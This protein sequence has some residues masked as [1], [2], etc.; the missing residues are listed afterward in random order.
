MTTVAQWAANQGVGGVRKSVQVPL[1]AGR[2]TATIVAGVSP[3]GR[4]VQ[5]FTVGTIGAGSSP[6]ETMK[7]QYLVP[8]GAAIDLSAAATAIAYAAT[9]GV[10]DVPMTTAAHS[11]G[12]GMQGY[13]P[14][15]AVLQI[16]DTVSSGTVAQAMALIEFTEDQGTQGA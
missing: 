3:V 14:A 2:S 15:G 6:V 9:S 13:V 11:D 16:V 5:K 12:N 10:T 1:A 8:G 7:L 4:V